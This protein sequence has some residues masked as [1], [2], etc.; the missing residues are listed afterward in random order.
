MRA[1]LLVPLHLHD[2]R[3]TRAE[4]VQRTPDGTRVDGLPVAVENQNGMFENGVHRLFL[5]K[6]AQASKE[7]R[8]GNRKAANGVRSFPEI[9]IPEA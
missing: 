6:R 7:P 3:V 4:Q 9:E 2:P 1:E 8:F 5:N